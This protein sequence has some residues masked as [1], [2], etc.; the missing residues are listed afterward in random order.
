MDKG[1]SLPEFKFKYPNGVR[2]VWGNVYDVDSGNPLVGVDVALNI[3]PDPNL[4]GTPE[5][6]QAK[7]EAARRSSKTG[8]RKDSPWSLYPEEMARKTA[9][10]RLAKRLPLSPEL[11]SAAVVDEYKEAGVSVPALELAVPDGEPM[12]EQDDAKPATVVGTDGDGSAR[13]P[14]SEG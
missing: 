4:E 12:P 2:A 13:E 10:R 6:E 9:I 1:W 3:N 11:L 7:I 8:D 5:S 14:G